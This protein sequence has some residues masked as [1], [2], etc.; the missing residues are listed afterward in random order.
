MDAYVSI[1][2][3]LCL[4]YLEAAYQS[5]GERKWHC[6]FR[7]A[8]IAMLYGSVAI[9]VNHHAL[10]ALPSSFHTLFT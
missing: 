8:T 1:Y 6:A 4:A 10:V 2:T 9:F 7:E 3:G 5:F